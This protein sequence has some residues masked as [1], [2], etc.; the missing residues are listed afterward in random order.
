[1]TSPSNN[2]TPSSDQSSVDPERRRFVQLLG[3]GGVVL[4]AGPDGIRR[5]SDAERLTASFAEPWSPVAYVTLHDDG[6][7]SIICHRSEMGPGD[8]HHHAHDH[9]R[10]NGSGLGEVSCGTG[11]WQRQEVRVAKHR[12]VH[13]YS[14]LSA[15][16]SRSRRYH[17][18]AAGRRGGKAVECEQ[19]RGEGAA[20]HGGACGQRSVHGIRCTRIDGAH[21]ADAGQGSRAHQVDRRERRWQGKK[22]PSVDLVPMTT[23]TA[24]YGADVILPGMKTAVI[25][26][27]PVWGGTVVS[28]DDSAALKV[29]GVERVIR[30]PEPSIP[31]GFKPLGGV[32]VVAKNTW[33]AIK[34]RDAPQDHV[35]RRSECDVRFSRLQEVAAGE[36][37]LTWQGGSHGGQR[38]DRTGTRVAPDLQRVL[39]PH[40]SH[41]QM[42]PV[43]SIA[44]MQTS[45]RGVGAHAVARRTRAVRWPSTSRWI[46]KRSRCV[47]AAGRCIRSEVQT[48][49]PLRECLSR[50]RGVGAP[51]R[52]QWTREDDMHFDSSTASRRIDWKRVWTPAAR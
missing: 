42:E 23:G 5:L 35:G 9:R 7:V 49:F 2:P 37:P 38:R 50:A 12:W 22:M 15:A 32:A 36:C 21:T 26:R 41:A 4:A 52:V 25:V 18:R 11:R 1:M 8:S 13:E 29:P 31:A 48:R 28:V 3:M 44:R 30:I 17:A 47:S 19:R 10:R 33:A 46:S 34:G 39:A 40:L 16:I 45:R 27:P 43:V 24:Q 6:M 51:V 20:A 14:R